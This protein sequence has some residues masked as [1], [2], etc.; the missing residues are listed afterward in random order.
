LSG[1][2]VNHVEITLDGGDYLVIEELIE[3]HLACADL[4]IKGLD[5]VLEV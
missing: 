2:V 4:V 5:A 3:L 1:T